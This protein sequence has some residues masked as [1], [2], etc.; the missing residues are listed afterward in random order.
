MVDYKAIADAI[1]EAE[2][3]TALAE[4]AIVHLLFK[5]SVT[6]DV[7]GKIVLV[8]DED[9]N[10]VMIPYLGDDGNQK[11]SD[12]KFMTDVNIISAFDKIANLEQTVSK[13]NSKQT[14][15]SLSSIIGMALTAKLEVFIDNAVSAGKLS[16]WVAIGLNGDGLNVNDPQVIGFLNKE[17]SDGNLDVDQVLINAI[18]GT[19][20]EIVK[21]FPN[22]KVGHVSTAIQKRFRGEV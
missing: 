8:L 5:K 20:N 7:L 22:L 11:T 3:N 15:I 9:G 12:G 14:Y 13:G 17:K 16:S 1:P 18:I 21:V 4:L 2:M 19:G 10:N 6:H